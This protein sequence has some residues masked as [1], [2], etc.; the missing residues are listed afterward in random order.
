MKRL[1]DLFFSA[2]GL[3]LLLPLLGLVGLLVWLQDRQH[4]LYKAERVG[5]GM[6]SF[7]MYK[8]RTMVVGADMLGGASTANS[9]QRITPI[10]S[11]LRKTKL[12]EIPQ[13]WNVLRGSMSF[14]GPRPNVAFDVAKY[15]EQE[16][17]LLSVRP[18]ITDFSSIVFSDEGAILEGA[19]DPDQAYDEYIRPWKIK[20]G[21]FYVRSS[22]L[23]I[24]VLLIFTTVL[25]VVSR[26][27]A[28]LATQSMLK[29]YGADRELVSYV[30]T[31]L[32]KVRSQ[33]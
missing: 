27:A 3:F 1:F 4:P 9:D 15:T 32:D 11:I 33:E 22:S 26:S 20:L 8:F 18:G 28:L 31:R 10:G 30:A 23:L 2:V 6:R 5:Q 14:V 16:K 25:N 13:L 24:D 21:L 17:I 29:A 7:V 19:H 12:D